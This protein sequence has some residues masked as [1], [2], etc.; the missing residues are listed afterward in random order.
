MT[1]NGLKDRKR[2]MIAEQ[3][4]LVKRQDTLRASLRKSEADQNSAI[5]AE[6]FAAAEALDATI[7]TLK[8]QLESSDAALAECAITVRR[9]TFVGGLSLLTLRLCSHS[10]E[11]WKVRST[12]SFK[13]DLVRYRSQ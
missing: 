1:L 4:S 7:A 9:L 11:A 3:E 10:C 12:I 6:D 13:R 8:A 5:E 2:A